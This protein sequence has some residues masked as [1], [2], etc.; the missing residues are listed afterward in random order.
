M[1]PQWTSF[2]RGVPLLASILILGN[3]G[4]SQQTFAQISPSGIPILNAEFF[5]FGGHCYGEVVGSSWAI[6]ESEAVSLGGH[7]VTIND[8]A[9]NAFIFSISG[10]GPWIGYNDKNNEG[11]FEWVSGEVTSGYDNFAT[12]EPSGD[13]D[14]V[15]MQGDGTWNDFP[16][17]G[18]V[19]T[20]MIELEDTCDFIFG[21]AIGGHLIS[22]DTTALLLA[23]AQSI[24]MWMIPVI[25][26]GV[27][28]G[29][30]VIKRRK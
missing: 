26:A 12:G 5:D 20:G 13:S 16:D 25:L 8:A 6:T 4:Y 9:E 14:V 29:V 1:V 24:S 2:H 22:V 11:I 18:Q 23:G 15:H 7:L 17:S 28:I 27:I 30:F 3:I 10:G 21:D 19:L